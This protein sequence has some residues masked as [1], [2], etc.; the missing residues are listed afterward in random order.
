MDKIPWKGLGWCSFGWER[1][2]RCWYPSLGTFS[3]KEG[4]NGH[5]GDVERGRNHWKG[6]EA[7]KDRGHVVFFLSNILPNMKSCAGNKEETENEE[8][9]T[10]KKEAA[11]TGLKHFW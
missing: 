1:L 8:R 3:L 2:R 11:E 10:E 7:G 5:E 6:K 4:L 9:M